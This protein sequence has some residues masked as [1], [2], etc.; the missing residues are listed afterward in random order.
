MARST[1]T[2]V[3]VT[4]EF[5]PNPDTLKYLVSQRL[6]PRGTLEI[7]TPAA[8]ASSPLAQRLFAVGGVRSLLIAKDFVTVTVTSQDRIME[9]NRA[10]L[11]EI[12]EHLERGEPIVTAPLPEQ[13]HGDQD[14]EVARQVIEILDARIRP[15]VAMDGG[16]ILFDRFEDGVVYLELKGSCHG[17]P[18]SLATLKMGI[19]QQLRALVPEVREVQAV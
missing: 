1:P 7:T 3:T 16:D 12:R 10:M 11:R 9:V 13:E 8:A 18:S 6:L 5:T 14:S 15:A 4:L 2:P 17:C 19:E